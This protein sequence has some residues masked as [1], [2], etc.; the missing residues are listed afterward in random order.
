MSTPVGYLVGLAV[1]ALPALRPPRLPRPLGAALFLTTLAIGELPVLAALAFGASTALAVVQGD[2]GSPVAAAAAVLAAGC[3]VLTAWRGARAGAVLRGAMAPTPVPSGPWWRV[4]LLPFAV[5]PRTVERVSD[6]V[7]GPA[8]RRHRFDLYRRRA[9][10]TGAPVL[11]HLHGG[12]YTTGH[13]SSQSLPLLHRLAERGWVCLSANYRLRPAASV[14]EHVEDVRRLVAWVRRHG[15]A[16]GA[17]P[18]RIVLSGSS[19]GA[20]MSALAACAPEGERTFEGV[21]TSVSAVVGLG[22]YWGR[23]F[24]RGPETSPTETV[25]ADAP[26]VMVV[27]GDHDSVVPV[28]NARLFAGRL[29]SVSHAPVVYA[30]LPG[31]QHG[32]DL[33]WSPRF[34]AVVN[35]VE[36]FANRVV[37]R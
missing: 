19:A 1:L 14:E 20:H 35:A 3:L 26:P 23:Y 9:G 34:T 18:G 15:E 27:H 29:R 5:R 25:G 2:L 7:Y 12:Y 28:E 31:G 13:K 33:F 6:L 30:E 17:D 4:L 21:D 11:I 16:W 32:F 22:G 36:A 10:V 37:G 8:G 24:G